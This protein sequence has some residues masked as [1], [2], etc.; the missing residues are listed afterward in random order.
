MSRRERVSK[1][2]WR[3]HRRVHQHRGKL[4]LR[5][6]RGFGVGARPENLRLVDVEMSYHGATFTRRGTN[7]RA[8]IASH[9]KWIESDRYT[10]PKYILKHLS[11][12][13][14]IAHHRRFERT[15]FTLHFTCSVKVFK[16]ILKNPEL[17]ERLKKNW[18]NLEMFRTTGGN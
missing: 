7:C 3:L 1:P 8:D 11:P 14:Y 10:Q 16:K 6:Q 18:E 12:R 15:C 17:Q 5:L 2:K 4:L 9:I 13:W